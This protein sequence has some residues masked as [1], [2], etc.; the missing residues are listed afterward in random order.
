MMGELKGHKNVLAAFSDVF[1]CQ[2]FGTIKESK[3]VIP[4]KQTTLASFDKLFD[5]IYN[6]DID[7]SV[8]T[9]LEMYDV[10]NLAYKYRMP[11]LLEEVRVQME[12]VTITMDNLMEVADTATQFIQ[13]PEVTTSE[14]DFLSNK[15]ISWSILHRAL[16][17]GLTGQ[18]SAPL[19][20]REGSFLQDS[21]SKFDSL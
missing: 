16:L 11:E 9:V 4:V 18:F 12:E 15:C 5:F 7:W 20:G 19:I 21:L 14:N 3:D 17:Y 2:F 1:R 6:K 10:A 13:F 8:L